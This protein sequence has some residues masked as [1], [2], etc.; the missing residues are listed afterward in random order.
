MKKTF[1]IL[2][3]FFAAAGAVFAQAAPTATELLRRIDDN[4]IY[5]TIVYEGEMIIEYQN[6]RYVKVMKTWA[7]GT[8][9][10]FI[11]F[12][13]AEDRGTKY[14]KKGA[15]LYVYSPDTEEVMLISGHMLKE[16]MM[17]SD[18]SYEDTIN[19]DSLSSRYDPV[20]SGSELWNGRDCWVLDLSAKKRTESYP[21]QKLWIDKENGDMLHNEQFA[22]SGAK[23]KEFTMLRVEII[24][25]RRFPVE[26][27]MRD[28][29][30]KN[31]K[32]TFVM[33]N[34][35]L[36]QPIADS[37]FSQRNLER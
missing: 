28:L 32:T 17:G 35:V 13:N 16:S 7:K 19:N 34:V 23:L 26:Y 18:L 25:G 33:K 5:T 36:D 14:L 37:V 31:S 9:D 30:R 8:A 24:G 20:I 29:L 22:L 2:A 3:V 27:E 11:E 12:T 1:F 10:S 15:R 21:R 6:R 4:E